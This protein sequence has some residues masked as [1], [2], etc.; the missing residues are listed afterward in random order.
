MNEGKLV[1]Q[2]RFNVRFNKR[3]AKKVIKRM[4]V[5]NGGSLSREQLT[6]LIKQRLKIRIP[7]VRIVVVP[8]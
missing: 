6:E 4:I 1:M 8:V 3:I 2:I 5:Q 7:K